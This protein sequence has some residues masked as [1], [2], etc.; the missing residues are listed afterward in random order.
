MSSAKDYWLIADQY[1]DLS[2]QV[3]ALIADSGNKW[4]VA[5]S[6]MNEKEAL[7]HH[8]EATKWT[9]YHQG[10]PVL[11]N[12]YHGIELLLKGFLIATNNT[13]ERNHKISFNLGLV[14]EQHPK[15][16]FVSHI[17]N[18]IHRNKLPDVLKE[19]VDETDIS[20]DDWYQA[21]KYPESM[22]GDVFA[23][24]I[25]K[26]RTDTGAIFFRNLSQA[27][28]EIRVLA[29]RYAREKGFD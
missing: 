15:A 3:S 8:E 5:Y 20:I 4:C 21:F 11:F 2:Q 29:I 18:Y 25:L 22:K 1:L 28:N 26:F 12:F 14:K 9:D 13:L 6:G 27:I 16:E 24:N 7:R 19:F 17:E 23:H 10:I